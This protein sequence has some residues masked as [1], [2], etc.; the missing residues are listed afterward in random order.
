[1]VNRRCTG[2]CTSIHA[3]NRSFHQEQLQYA[4][5]TH[6]LHLE[7]RIIA[8]VNNCAITDQLDLLL[9]LI[10]F[11]QFCSLFKQPPKA[12]WL[13]MLEYGCLGKDTLVR[14]PYL[15]MLRRR[16]PSKGLLMAERNCKSPKIQQRFS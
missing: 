4:L 7:R 11:I 2:V 16:I 15:K 6:C 3:G 5:K 10:S 8:T 1:M 12:C 14:K 13:K 9:F